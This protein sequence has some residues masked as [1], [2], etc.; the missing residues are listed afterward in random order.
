MP[1]ANMSKA[2]HYLKQAF[3]AGLNKLDTDELL[4]AIAKHVTVKGVWETGVVSPSLVATQ[5]RLARLKKFLGDEAQPGFKRLA[6]RAG[7]ADPITQLNFLRGF[8]MEGAIVAALISVLGESRIMGNA[9]SLLFRWRYQGDDFQLSS[10]QRGEQRGMVFAGHPDMMVWSEGTQQSNWVP[11]LELIQIKTPSI[12][13]FERVDK[14]GDEDAL[15]TY[16]GQMATEMYIGRRMG[17]PIQRSHLLLATWEGTPK[18]TDPHCRIATMEWHESLAQIPE[19]V[20]RQLIQD[21]DAAYTMGQWPA[22]YPQHK[23]DSWPCQYCNFS[24]LATFDTIGC[25]EQSEWE[26]FAQSGDTR[27]TVPQVDQND[28]QVIPM[29]RRR[30]S[31]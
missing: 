27:L 2:M 26:R 24:R 4:E 11:E 1:T 12:Y 23:W 13:K 28:P 29:R 18:I 10:W 17:Y 7:A 9:P 3:Y 30:R 14:L 25:E 31:A 8:C 16:R 22:P 15:E 6:V 5:C 19:E 21:Y 20:G